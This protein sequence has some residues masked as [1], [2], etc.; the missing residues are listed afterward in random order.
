MSEGCLPR[1]ES[2]RYTRCQ[3]FHRH[4]LSEKCKRRLWTSNN[5]SGHINSI[6]TRVDLTNQGART[7]GHARRCNYSTR[8]RIWAIWSRLMKI[9]SWVNSPWMICSN[10]SNLNSKS[11]LYHLEIENLPLSRSTLKVLKSHKV[12]PV[13]YTHLTLPTICSV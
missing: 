9:L 8:I 5:S 12:T 4:R 1:S 10:R 6:R 7:Q 11:P 3:D 2:L 13:S